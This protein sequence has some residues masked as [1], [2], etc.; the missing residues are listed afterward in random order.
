MYTAP[1]INLYSKN[2]YNIQFYFNEDLCVYIYTYFSFYLSL[3][4][5]FFQRAQLKSVNLLT[6]RNK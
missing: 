1:I 3:E 4:Y 5:L 6:Q 2:I